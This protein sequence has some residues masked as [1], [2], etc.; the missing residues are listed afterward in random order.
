MNK[1]YNALLFLLFVP[2]MLL[3]IIVGLDVPLPFLHTTG[4]NL[5]YKNEA[6]IVLGIFMCLTNVR[7]SMRRWIAMKLV[8]Q[9]EK[10]TWNSVVSKERIKR[11]LLYNYL[12]AFIMFF[13]AL[14]LYFLADE[15]IVPAIVLFVSSIDEV[16]FAIY[17]KAANKFRLGF[18][19]KA[20][21]AGDRDV[22][23]IY[24]KGLR[25]VSIHQQT[26]YFDFKDDLHMRFPID[27]IPVESREDFFKSFI[28]NIDE[29]IVYIENNIPR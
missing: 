14:G 29:S 10:Y 27:L 25:R 16:F 1:F 22:T 6:F 5:P 20:L 12:E 24:F 18:T 4:A 2:T 26:L 17:G 3:A 11:V 8:N 9:I 28:S 7:R 23:V 21:L 15:A 19:S 13:S